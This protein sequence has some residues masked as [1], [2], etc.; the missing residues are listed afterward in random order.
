MIEVT[1]LDFLIGIYLWDHP[2]KTLAFLGERQMIMPTEGCGLYSE[3][4]NLRKGHRKGLPK[5]EK[6]PPIQ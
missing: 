5:F 2:F 6:V 4:N 3:G 1:S